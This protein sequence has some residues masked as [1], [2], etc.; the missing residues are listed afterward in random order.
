[1]KKIKKQARKAETETQN[2]KR[3]KQLDKIPDNNVKF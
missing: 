3:R 2:Q 1:M